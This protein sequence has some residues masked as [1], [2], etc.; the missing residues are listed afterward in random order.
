ERQQ[1]ELALGMAVW[2]ALQAATMYLALE[3]IVR[4]RWPGKLT[5][6]GR[7]LAG[8]WRDPMVGRDVLIGMAAAVSIPLIRM[9]YITTAP[10]LGLPGAMP[11]F[12]TGPGWYLYPGPLASPIMLFATITPAATTPVVLLMMA[13][14]YHMAFRL[15]W[16]AWGLFWLTQAGIF[17][18]PLLGPADW[19]NVYL[20]ACTLT[21]VLVYVLVQA[22]FGLLA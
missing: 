5:S 16:L 1:L 7:L 10:R 3:P 19:G 6:W 21:G 18:T 17:L 11:A 9:L 13:C 4:R 20:M 14:L 12:G 8:R 2:E 15:P 22:R